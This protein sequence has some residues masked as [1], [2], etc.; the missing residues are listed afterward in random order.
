MVETPTRASERAYRRFSSP[1]GAPAPGAFRP[2]CAASDADDAV[3]TPVFVGS[4]FGGVRIDAPLPVDDELVFVGSR[5]EL[6]FL[7]ERAVLLHHAVGTR[8]P[9]VEV[10]DQERFFAGERALE[11]REDGFR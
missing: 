10:P 7:V 1:A 4:L 11:G 6:Q 3:E 5:R 8:I 9:V 2:G